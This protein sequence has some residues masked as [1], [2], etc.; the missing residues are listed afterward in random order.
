M[1]A[2]AA[3]CGAGFAAAA[4]ERF[5]VYNL[6]TSTDFTG[7]FPAPAGSQTWGP[8]QALNDRDHSLDVT[9]RLTIT[10]IGHGRFDVKLQTRTRQ[11]CIKRDV[12]LT[13][14]TIFD[15]RDADIA[16]CRP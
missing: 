2:V 10:G 13:R 9:E 14:E 15:I 6:T 5:F 16:G 12:D 11:T 3:W 7:V 4:T 1:L 8:N